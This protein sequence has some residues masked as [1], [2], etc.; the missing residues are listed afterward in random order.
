M[1]KHLLFIHSTSHQGS[2]VTGAWKLMTELFLL[3][4]DGYI[5][6]EILEVI[7]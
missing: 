3:S 4:L 1:L 2:E 7:T 6:T 5:E